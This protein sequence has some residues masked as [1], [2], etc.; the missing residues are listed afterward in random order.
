VFVSD[1]VSDNL[2][3]RDFAR[4]TS[5]EPLIVRHQGKFVGILRKPGNL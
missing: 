1:D 4:T 5:V 2:A 3:F